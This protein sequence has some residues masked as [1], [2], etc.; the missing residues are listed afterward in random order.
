MVDE[1]VNFRNIN[2]EKRYV[3][4]VLPDLR[5]SFSKQKLK[6]QI[7]AILVIL[8][9]IL[10]VV[11]F[12]VCWLLNAHTNLLHNWAWFSQYENQEYILFYIGTMITG[13]GVYLFFKLFYDEDFNKKIKS[14]YMNILL[15]DFPNFKWKKKASLINDKELRSSN[16]FVKYNSTEIDDAFHGTYKGIEF[17][18]AEIDMV[19]RQH[20]PRRGVQEFPVF[21]GLIFYLMQIKR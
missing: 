14:R 10:T 19:N 18:V 7:L 5:R 3:K 8:Y 13:Y 20:R 21:K 2:I 11:W 12:P 4:E 9:I 16:L 6:F 1:E 15:Q 17:E